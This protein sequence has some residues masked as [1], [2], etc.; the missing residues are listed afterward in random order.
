M[1]KLILFV[2]FFGVAIPSLV[3]AN[4]WNP[5]TWFDKSPEVPKTEVVPVSESVLPQIVHDT[6]IVE[7][8]VF[9]TKTVVVQD[10]VLLAKIA[11]LTKQSEQLKA[12]MEKLNTDKN[13]LSQKITTLETIPISP[14]IG[15]CKQAKE[16]MVV[17]AEELDK[18]QKEFDTEYDKVAHASG[19]S[20]QGTIQA[21]ASV[22][23]KY[24]R[25][26]VSLQSEQNIVRTKIDLYCQ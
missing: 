21:I 20:V 4:W 22:K 1:K 13:T 2:L 7:K 17:K 24:G 6:K 12:E 15:E 8:P 16:D 3:F 19:G 11:E 10:P 26:K 25:K 9:Q 18:L 23:D 5:L 14:T